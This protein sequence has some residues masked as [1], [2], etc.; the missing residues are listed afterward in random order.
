MLVQVDK[1]SSDKHVHFECVHFLNFYI[2]A[3]VYKMLKMFEQKSENCQMV[4]SS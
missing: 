3:T 4:E 1:I 2:K